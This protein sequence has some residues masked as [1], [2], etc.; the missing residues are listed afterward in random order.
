M[1]FDFNAVCENCWYW[2]KITTGREVLGFCK[3]HAPIVVSTPDPQSFTGTTQT[4][5]WPRT[6]AEDTCGDFTY[7]LVT[8]IIPKREMAPNP[9]PSEEYEKCR[10]FG[11][12]QCV[13]G[14]K[15]N[16]MWLEQFGTVEN[17]AVSCSCG[18]KS[19]NWS[20]P[21]DALLDWKLNTQT[22]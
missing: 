7:N 8:E 2:E 13:C 16:L 18:R 5:L 20:N 10:S 1:T 3:R 9:V 6:V 15:P 14:G 22:K 4:T 19:Q 21:A 11:V 12:P 17:F